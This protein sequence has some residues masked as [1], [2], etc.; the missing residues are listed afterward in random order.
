MG[1]VELR[2]L[3]PSVISQIYVDVYLYVCVY[4]LPPV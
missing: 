3:A 4:K 2:L 1:I